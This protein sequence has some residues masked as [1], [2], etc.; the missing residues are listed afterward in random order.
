MTTEGR[1]NQNTPAATL[2]SDLDALLEKQIKAEKTRKEYQD[3]PETK[4]KRK[5]YQ[6][7]QYVF[8]QIARAAIKGDRVKL[9]E[10]GVPEEQVEAAIEKAASLVAA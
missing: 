9:V 10:L 4:E 7:S 6:Q 5:A 2:P 1:R 3:R 8:R